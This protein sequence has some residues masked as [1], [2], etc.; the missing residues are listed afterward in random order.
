MAEEVDDGINT[1]RRSDQEVKFA[2]GF[3]LLPE[4]A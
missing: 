3:A 4:K 1:G 2:P